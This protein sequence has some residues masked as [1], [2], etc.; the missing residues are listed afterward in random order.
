MGRKPGKHPGDDGHHLAQVSDPDEIEVH[1]PGCCSGC[2]ADLL[3]AV[4]E[5]VEVRQVFDLPVSAVKYFPGFAVSPS[6]NSLGRRLGIPSTSVTEF[7]G[8]CGYPS[9]R[10]RAR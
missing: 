10:L 1:A 5:G 6:R 8:G 2:G 3:G 9:L 7:L 4:V